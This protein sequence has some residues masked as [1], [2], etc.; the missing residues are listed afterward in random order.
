MSESW[1]YEVMK[2]KVSSL[3]H[4][5]TPILFWISELSNEIVVYPVKKAPEFLARSNTSKNERST[6]VMK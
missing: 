1:G 4:F 5:V 3:Q 2:K 6:G